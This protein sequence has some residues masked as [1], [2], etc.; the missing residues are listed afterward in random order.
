MNTIA[1]HG[2]VIRNAP[3]SKLWVVG[4][5]APCAL[6][7]RIAALTWSMP[8]LGLT[9]HTK[10]PALRSSSP[11]VNTTW[12]ATSSISFWRACPMHR[13]AQRYFLFIVPKFTVAA[14]G[15]GERNT[16]TCGSIEG[17]RWASML[18]A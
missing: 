14:D 3:G 17:A 12:P 8:N 15:I 9:A 18:P 16:V 1:E 11:L 5:L 10:S 2:T 4:G 7:S 13:L 6:L